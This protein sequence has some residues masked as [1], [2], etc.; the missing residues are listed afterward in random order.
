LARGRSKQGDVVTVSVSLGS[1]KEVRTKV[2]DRVEAGS[3]E[4]IREQ[5]RKAT[6]DGDT[7]P[8]VI[9]NRVQTQAFIDE[10][11]DE[12]V[13]LKNIRVARRREPSG[14]I[15][16]LYFGEPVT[17]DASLTHSE[18]TPSETS[19]TYDTKK[20][21]SSFDLTSDFME[22][23][24][25]ASP[26]EARKMIASM[27]A[28]QISNDLE[29]LAIAGDESI[30][31]STTASDRLL[32]TNDGFSAIMD[33]SLPSG[34]DIDA[35]GAGVSKKL[36]FDMIRALP[37]K[38]KRNKPNYRFILPPSLAENWTYSISEVATSMGDSATKGIQ[39]KPFGIPLLE[40]PL[41]PE[42]IEYSSAIT[43]CAEIWLCDPKNLVMIL[44]R[45]I[46]W[47]WERNPRSD[48]WEA[49]IHTRSDFLI[50]IEK[51]VVRAKNV[52]ITGTAYTG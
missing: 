18:R 4:D 9:L 14:E 19:V 11:V 3:L 36:F 13:L 51:A 33:D 39:V 27:F 44:Q 25:A 46:K 21:R 30:S 38:W 24:K 8:S 12:S 49:T 26:A 7:L 20:A 17:E 15:N 42:D 35:E 6:I 5:I 29:Y 1:A 34:Q 32:R 48:L 45:S 52:S 16:R 47:E 41:M 31:G 2:Q 23:I 10:T 28:K 50:E 37:S 43:D 40:V 22:D